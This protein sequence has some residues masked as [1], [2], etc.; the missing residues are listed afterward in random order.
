MIKKELNLYICYTYYHLLIAIIK[1]IKSNTVSDIIISANFTDTILATDKELIKRLKKSKVFNRVIIFN[2]SEE[3]NKYFWKASFKKIS[4]GN[5]LIKNNEYD[6]SIYK[7]IYVFY[8]V[9]TIGYMLNKQKIHY[10]LLEDGMDCFKQKYFNH[11]FRSSN[12]LLK[13]IKNFLN[14]PAATESQYIK[15]IEVN[16]ASDL[17]IKHSNLIEAPKKEMFSS[18]N[19]KDKQ[20][21]LNIFNI[22]HK[23]LHLQNNCTLLLTQPFLK[24]DENIKLNIYKDMLDTYAKNENII[25]KTHPGEKTNYNKYFENYKNIQII[26]KTFPIEILSFLNIRFKQILTISSTA[27]NFIENADKKIELGDDYL[28]SLVNY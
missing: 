22:N 23:S 6:F 14:V 20:I 15:S 7:N 26:S 25:I 13:A 2:H 4:I 11:C 12:K 28:H 27:I 16:D 21:I 3:E 10:H 5:K 8:D 18:L 24:I 17:F 19:N 9:T 1:A